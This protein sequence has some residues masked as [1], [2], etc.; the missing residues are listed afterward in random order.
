MQWVRRAGPRRIWVDLE[1]VADAHEHVL[2]LDLE[3][4]EDQLAMAAMLLRA[5]DRDAAHDLPA[6]LVAVEQE[7][8]EPAARIVRGAGDDDEVLR[9]PGPGDEP[10][11]ALDDPPAAA[12]G[13]PGADHAGIR[14]AARRR[15]GHGEGRADA[16][17]DDRAQPAVLLCRRGDL[18]QQ[19]HVAVVGSGGVEHDR[20]EDRAVG[21][22]V[23]H[24]HGQPR[25]AHAAQLLRRLRRPQARGHCLGLQSGQA[26]EA[27]VLVLVPGGAIVLHR[28]DK[29]A[30]EGARAPL[31]LG[32]F[33]IE[34]EIHG[35]VA[36]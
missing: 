25:Q 22:L 17:V 26:I 5:H 12:S 32:E 1:P 11:A 18:G 3:A 23:H 20:P 15:L 28:H 19:H 10:F 13:R 31:Q 30:D 6:G 21:L 2:V 9:H 7:G 8:G 29:V 16:A 34:G 14:A 24:G 27:D 33:G 35:S 36:G 4:G